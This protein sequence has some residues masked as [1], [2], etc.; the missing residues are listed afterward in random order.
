MATKKTENTKK[1]KTPGL[2]Q[3]PREKTGR[4]R[5]AKPYPSNVVTQAY[6]AKVTGVTKSAVSKSPL[7]TVSDSKGN[8]R[9]DLNDPEVQAYIEGK[10][11]VN[12]RRR[13][14]I[15]SKAE[16][17]EDFGAGKNHSI[18]LSADLKAIVD[19]VNDPV[20]KLNVIHDAEKV[21]WTRERRIKVQLENAIRKKDLI[22]VNIVRIWIGAFVPGIRNNLLPLG[23][24]IARGDRALQTRIDEEI[25]RAT[26]KLLESSIRLV[27][28]SDVVDSAL[29]DLISEAEEDEQ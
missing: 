16:P 14:K 24:R 13:T 23:K 7:P 12:R 21:E 1:A 18:Y 3:E 29:S 9:Y 10:R 2:P 4:A 11:T 22:P 19:S 25:Q 5:G 17:S 27:Q 26:E 28:D 8:K 6:I 15:H 20:A